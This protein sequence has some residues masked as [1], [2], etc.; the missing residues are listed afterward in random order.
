MLGLLF[1]RFTIGLIL[2]I[3]AG[4]LAYNKIQKWRGRADEAPPDSIETVDIVKPSEV[5]K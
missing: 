4:T 3:V 1:N 2:I 5:S